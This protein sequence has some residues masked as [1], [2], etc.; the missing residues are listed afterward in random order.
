MTHQVRT[1]RGRF[2]A[3]LLAAAWAGSA[4][5]FT[6][7]LGAAELVRITP[8][9]IKAAQREGVMSFRYSAQK[10][11]TE[12]LVGEFSK[13]FPGI[14][15]QLDRRV[16]AAGTQ[17]FATEERAGRHIVDV[18][19]TTDRIGLKQLS[20]QGLYLNYTIPDLKKRF[21]PGT[22]VEGWGYAPAWTELVLSYNPDRI[23]TEKVRP[24]F[25]TWNGLLDPSLG[26][27]KIGVVDPESATQAFA[28]L[29][30]F[31][32][33]PQYG[34]AFVEKLSAQ[35][36]KIYRGSAQGREALAAGEIDVLLGDVEHININ[37]FSAGSK[38]RWTFPE[39]VPAYASTYHAISKNAP[40]PNA[41]RL[42][43]AWILSPD[44]AAAMQRAGVR[45][46]L[47]GLPDTRIAL[48]KLKQTSWWKPYPE[49]NRWV[50]DKDMWDAKYKPLLAEMKALLRM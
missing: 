50:P 6:A 29:W 42:Y 25:A 1:G 37:A 12:Y 43:V 8:E 40:H 11:T 28:V 36:P 2:A 27:G 33:R 17:Q 30:M 19:L 16:G 46:T 35:K 23:S 44:G 5:F 3:W 45:P 20:Q 47:A 18:H 9:L 49:Q 10:D 32:D 4:A 24:L 41:A 22:Y 21:P 31:L 14:T 13:Q 7:P 26:G 39:V 48:E 34:R 38:L 15:V